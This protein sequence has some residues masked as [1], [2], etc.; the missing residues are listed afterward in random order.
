[1]TA[2]KKELEDR[3]ARIEERLDAL[4]GKPRGPIDPV[5]AAR[6]FADGDKSAWN[7]YQEQ[8]RKESNL[9]GKTIP[10]NRVERPVPEGKPI[11]GCGPVMLP[12]KERGASSVS[13]T[14]NL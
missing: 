4:D 5:A 7:L 13:S 12:A 9:I 2:T 8:R 6:A 3:I 1:M 10:R 14:T 11:N